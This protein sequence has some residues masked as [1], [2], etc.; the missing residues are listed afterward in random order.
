MEDILEPV[1][2][3]LSAISVGNSS[4]RVP[5]PARVLELSQAQVEALTVDN[6]ILRK[7]VKELTENNTVKDSIID[8]QALRENLCHP[9]AGRGR[10]CLY[11]KSAQT[12]SGHRHKHH[13]SPEGGGR[14]EADDQR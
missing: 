6:G 8:H 12:T 1:N 2:R 3:N 5:G 13:L 4:Q 11:S 7:T 10:P 9:R 14:K